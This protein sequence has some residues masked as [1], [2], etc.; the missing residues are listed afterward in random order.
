MARKWFFVVLQ[1]N[2]LKIGCSVIARA[3][4]SKTS[5][6]EQKNIGIKN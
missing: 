1:I 5:R 3:N 4:T 2:T 6:E